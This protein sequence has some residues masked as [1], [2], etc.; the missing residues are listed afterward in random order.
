MSL[1]KDGRL[2][3]EVSICIARGMGLE[4]SEGVCPLGS[5]SEEKGVGAGRQEAGPALTQP[6]TSRHTWGTYRV[7]GVV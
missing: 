5:Q 2:E 1:Q 6:S 3:G 4:N 7:P